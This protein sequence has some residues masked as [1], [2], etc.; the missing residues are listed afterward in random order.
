MD[1]RGRGV[2]SFAGQAER[3][4]PVRGAC[5]KPRSEKAAEWNGLKFLLCSMAEVDQIKSYIGH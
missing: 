5:T 1:S 3:A 2:R 4:E